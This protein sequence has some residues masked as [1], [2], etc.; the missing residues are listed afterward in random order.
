MYA[1]GKGSTVPSDAQARE[2]LALYVYEYLLHVGAQKAA[3]T[4]LSEIRWEKNITLGEPPGFLHSWWCVFWDLYCA[5]PERRDTCEHSSEA[6]A[7]HDY[8]FVNSGY[9]VNGITHNAGPAPSP[10]GQ[11]PPNDG[12][13]GGPMPPGF[14]PPFMGPRYGG[15][16]PRPNVRMPQIGNEFN[17]VSFPPGQPLMSNNMDPTRQGEGGEFV[18]W[19]GPP[20]MN[21]MNPRM[22]PPRGP[23]MAPMAP[24]GYGPG[25]RAPPPNANLGPGS[26]PPMG[27]MGGPGGRPQWQPVTSTFQPMSYSSSSPGNYESM[28]FQAP[29]GSTGPPGP[30]TPIMPS[31][32]GSVGPYSPASHRMPTPSPV[33]RQAFISDSSN[34]GGENMYTMMKPVPGGNM[35]GDFPMSGGPEGGNMGPIGPNSM[36]PVLNGDGME[37]MKNSPA[38]GGPGTPRE[39]S[40]SGMGDYNLGGFGGPGENDQTE[41]AAILKI[42][43]SMQEEAKRFEKDSD[44]PDFFMQ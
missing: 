1:K 13:P 34:S 25:M 30:G 24:G 2:K 41:S 43:E 8:G 28:R 15:P 10:L 19:Q 18:G 5:A 12:M 14:F 39:D 17:G 27:P 26:G 4:F 16:G 42:K 11:M 3:Q 6:K 37:G 35:P 23:G 29:P 7:F 20:G 21:P 33:T 44:H 32:Q 40:G 22:N 31:P 36:G 38:N 9:G